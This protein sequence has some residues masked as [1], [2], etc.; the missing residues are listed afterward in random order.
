MQ[1]EASN[2]LR[3]STTLS[4]IQITDISYM[5]KLAAVFENWTQLSGLKSISKCLNVS[6]VRLLF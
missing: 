1:F 3:T 5:L 6:M 4:L 2:L